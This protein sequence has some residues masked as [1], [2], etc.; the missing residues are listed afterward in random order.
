[1][2]STAVGNAAYLLEIGWFFGTAILVGVLTG[3]WVDSRTGHEPLFTLIGIVLGLAV[4][5]Y[6]G[7]RM[8]LSYMRRFGGD[9]PAKGPR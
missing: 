1:M 4:A 2:K 6:G 8:L 3:V 9:P 5:L 7:F